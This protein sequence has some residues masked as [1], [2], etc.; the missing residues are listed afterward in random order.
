[1]PSIVYAQLRGKVVGI[2][3]GDTFT[4]LDSNKNQIKIRFHGI[5][6]P[7]KSQPFS[8]ASKKYLSE[9]IYLKNVSIQISGT[10]RYGRTLGIVFLGNEVINEKML[11]A[12]MAWHFK[13]YD[14]REVWA[15]LEERA[16]SQRIGLWQEKD[17]IPPWKWRMEKRKSKVN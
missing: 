11:A 12:G 6:C 4:I 7:E 16:R 2:T 15:K 14:N 13:Q 9:L 1:M 17:P 8:Y 3:D 5:D 10:D